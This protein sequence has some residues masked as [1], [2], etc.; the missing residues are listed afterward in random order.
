MT[1]AVTKMLSTG[2][3]DRKVV[4]RAAEDLL[5]NICFSILH[6]II[7][8]LYESPVKSKKVSC[9]TDKVFVDIKDA[10]KD[11]RGANNL[12]EFV[13]YFLSPVHRIQEQISAVD[14]DFLEEVVV[15]LE[16]K[17]L[18]RFMENSEEIYTKY[19]KRKRRK[20]GSN[21]RR[22]TKK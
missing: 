3:F 4:D 12:Q 8:P 6:P 18:A 10:V 14:D 13:T 9:Y 16:P 2:I 19:F 1:D 17:V 5:A 20:R 15:D 22:K 11:A 21:V 7:M